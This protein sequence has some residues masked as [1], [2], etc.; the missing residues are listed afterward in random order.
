M[1]A[2]DGAEQTAAL[3]PV[4]KDHDEL[5]PTKEIEETLGQSIQSALDF[6]NWEQ[7]GGFKG[8]QGAQ[9][10]LVRTLHEQKRLMRDVRTTVLSELASFPNAPAMA[11]VYKATPKDIAS[12]RR[13]VLL[14]GRLT[15]ARGASVSHESLIA[16]VVSVGVSLTQYDGR[17]RS[18][19]T[20]FLRHDCD[21]GANNI[22]DEIRSVLNQR[23]RRSRMGP[24][25]RGSDSV[26]RLLRR[27]LQS[28]AERKSLLE[29]S[30]PGWH[31]GYGLPAPYEL[32]TGS[33][34][35][36]LIDASLPILQSLLLDDKHWVF[37]PDSLSSLAFTTLASAL[38]PGELAIIQKAKPTLDNI[39]ER[40][41]FGSEYRA[42][43]RKFV[44]K[45]GDVI[46]LGGFRAT[47]FAPAQLF[48]AHA[49]KAIHAGLIAMA[50]AELQPHRGFPLLLELAGISAKMGLGVDA[51][52]SM[53][54][55]AYARVDTGEF[56]LPMQSTLPQA[57][58]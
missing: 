25:S 3:P 50:D 39:V 51:F 14:A 10:R 8:L 22:V 45:A 47:P 11:G 58:D 37:V 36:D 46:V 32:L 15:A 29:K 48:F 34:S 54:E 31:I 18:W 42:K 30:A 56:C 43:V 44:D 27:A 7:G 33:G 49:E 35:M 21:A 57:E 38:R 52:H 9:T 2:S 19:R 4:G 55:S 1:T 12:A 17:I 53:M 40:G 24:G 41:H 16:N 20:M 13:N 23:A 28:A 5:V 26:T 6:A